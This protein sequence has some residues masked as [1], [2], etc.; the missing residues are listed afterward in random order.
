MTFDVVI[1][2]GGIVGTSLAYALGGT[3]KVAI[4]EA[5][6][7]LGY[8][9]TGRSAALFSGAYGSEFVWRLSRCARPFLEAPPDGFVE[10]PLLKPRG[11][12]YIA[13][14]AAVAALKAFHAHASTLV[15]H[16]E[17]GD[18]A[19]VRSL[20]PALRTEFIEAGLLDRAASDI[21]VA[22]LHEGFIRGAKAAGAQIFTGV[23]VDSIVRDG[24]SWRVHA[25]DSCWTS[26]VVVN[27][28]GAW[29]D[30]VAATAG[31]RRVGLAALR[32]TMITVEAPVRYDTARWPLVTDLEESFYF[33]PDAG[34]LLISPGDETPL[35]PCDAAPEEWDVAVAAD[36]LETLTDIPVRRILSRWAGLR[37]FA[38]DRLPVVGFD[39]AAPGFFWLAGL[40]GFGVQTSP[41]LGRLAAAMI[42]GRD[43]PDDLRD[44][45]IDPGALGAGRFAPGA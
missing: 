20:V 42:A 32:R 15:P 6:T 33:K 26:P 1:I 22:L 25:G 4:L 40:G 13:A 3:A 23:R 29:A 30:Q 14:G 27:A 8:H 18:E 10:A 7:Q 24:T 28:A 34:R 9:A 45:G 37:T 16:L 39:G 5:E 44:A 2:G 21:E 41:A 31:V 19:F 11:T 36:R 35:E 43:I 38:P 17:F 12:L